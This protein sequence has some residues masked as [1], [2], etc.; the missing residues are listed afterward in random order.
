MSSCV[1]GPPASR[2][3]KRF[4]GCRERYHHAPSGGI[5][6]FSVDNFPVFDYMRPNVFVIADSNHGFKMVGVGKEVAA[7]LC[8][9]SSKVLA[10]FR[11]SRFV[12]GELHPVS[13]SPFPWA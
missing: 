5:G 13:N 2:A 4:E 12:E 9:Q 3:L 10:P 7:V 1:T 11:Y 8:G 6:C